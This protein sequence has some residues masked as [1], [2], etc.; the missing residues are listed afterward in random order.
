MT[1]RM[2]FCIILVFFSG[3]SVYAQSAGASHKQPR[4][5]LGAT[6]GAGA[7]Y[8]D[9][10][11]GAM[12]GKTNYAWNIGFYSRIDL[13]RFLSLQ[14]EVEYERLNARFPGGAFYTEGISVPVS[15]LLISPPD[16]FRVFAQLGGYYTYSTRGKALGREMDFDL[17][18]RSQR[19]GIIFGV[20]IQMRKATVRLLGKNDFTELLRHP[21]DYNLLNRTIYAVLDYRF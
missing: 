14:P 17:D 15:L 18:F 6:I 20:G 19:G 10:T 7:N 12:R 9:F 1:K 16:S 8:L 13:F 21:V 4:M 11:R 3:I 5:T 2:I